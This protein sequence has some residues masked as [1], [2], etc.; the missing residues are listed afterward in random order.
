MQAFNNMATALSFVI[1]QFSRFMSF[2]NTNYDKIKSFLDLMGNIQSGNIQGIT[3]NLKTLGVP[4]FANGVENFG[5][6][7]AYVHKGEVLANLPKGT[8]VIPAR[9]VNNSVTNSPSIN[10]NN[11]GGNTNSS[12]LSDEIMFRLRM[13]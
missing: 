12:E 13:L 9:E 3:T 10:I 2:I 1:D 6:G 11:Y 5:G 8:D 7:L 4:G